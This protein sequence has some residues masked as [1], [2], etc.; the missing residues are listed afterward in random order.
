MRS[1]KTLVIPV[2]VLVALL[3]AACGGATSAS[4]SPASSD[5]TAPA[6]EVGHQEATGAARQAS[7]TENP[8][9]VVVAVEVGEL[10]VKASQTTFK[11]GVPYRL[12]VT[13][14]GKI[15]HEVMI[16]PPVDHSSGMSM[17]GLDEMALAMIHEH[18]L[19]PGMTAT[20]E[21]TFQQAGSGQL[22]AAC[23]L[24]GHYEAGM[25]QQLT[26]IAS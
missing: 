25:K 15:A 1:K 26:I 4:N 5:T 3:A 20:L 19:G 6:A 8:D 12:V 10:Y 9:A 11:V 23:H 18:D 16:M 24:P 22:E 2:L 14:S 21:L 7:G 17:E 13:N